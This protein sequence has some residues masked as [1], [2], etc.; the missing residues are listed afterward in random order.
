MP[1]KI[2]SAPVDN[3]LHSHLSACRQRLMDSRAAIDGTLDLIDKAMDLASDLAAT[4][5]PPVELQQFFEAFQRQIAQRPR[6]EEPKEELPNETE[7][8]VQLSLV[9]RS[10]SVF[11][12]RRKLHLTETEYEVL[13]HLWEA[14]PNVVSRGELL[15]RLYGDEAKPGER[16]IDVFISHIRQKLKLASDGHEFLEVVRGQGWILRAETEQIRE[17]RA[18][19]ARR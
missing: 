12:G 17:S 13:E 9:A 2:S 5:S 16:T 10:R 4:S 8:R 3:D 7:R 6:V 19:S 11:V 15:S 1:S 14:K 18:S